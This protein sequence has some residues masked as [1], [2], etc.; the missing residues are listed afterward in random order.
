MGVQF[1]NGA[2]MELMVP[3]I[4]STSLE[5]MAK[6]LGGLNTIVTSLNLYATFNITPDSATYPSVSDSVTG[7]VYSGTP[8][9][10]LAAT[11]SGY[12]ETIYLRLYGESGVITNPIAEV[13]PVPPLIDV[14]G[15]TY[16]ITFEA[17]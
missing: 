1:E 9:G 12:I 3:T 7:S 14:S 16:T 17:I 10:N 2:G 13:T 6:R 5:F 11:C 8:V 15:I 4:N